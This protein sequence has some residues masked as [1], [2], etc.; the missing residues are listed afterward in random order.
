MKTLTNKTNKLFQRDEFICVVT[1]EIMK[2][3]VASN[4]MPFLTPL[5]LLGSAF[6]PRYSLVVN[7]VSGIYLD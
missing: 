2:D 6:L 4:K 3:I 7:I 1:L 5:P